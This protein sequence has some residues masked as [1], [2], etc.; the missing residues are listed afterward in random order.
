MKIYF[1]FTFIQI[2]FL[3]AHSRNIELNNEE[4][5]GEI[6][7]QGPESDP[8]TTV[9]KMKDMFNKDDYKLKYSDMNFTIGQLKNIVIGLKAEK[10]GAFLIP[11]G[12]SQ[13]DKNIENIEF[14]FFVAFAIE[15]HF[16]DTRVKSHKENINFIPYKD[17]DDFILDFNKDS[18]FE[19]IYEDEVNYNTHDRF[20]DDFHENDKDL[21]I[22]ANPLVV[23]KNGGDD[24]IKEL[25][26]AFFSAFDFHKEFDYKTI[27][28][29]IIDCYITFSENDDGNDLDEQNLVDGSDL[30]TVNQDDLQ[31]ENFNLNIDVYEEIMTNIFN[32]VLRS[33]MFYVSTY[34]S[35]H[36]IIVSYQSHF[37]DNQQY[38]QFKNSIEELINEGAKNIDKKIINGIKDIMKTWIDK[39]KLTEKNILLESLKENF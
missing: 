36:D 22:T 8:V 11:K 19:Q 28:D 27:S 6:K 32:D 1:I 21:N 7:F 39:E 37:S 18:S 10:S 5:D 34:K 20:P 17:V 23:D 38:D 13:L 12:D 26:K 4:P 2:L 30:A 15:N 33:N 35:I 14:K 31:D 29:F 24:A 3:R 9:P 25:I 16:F